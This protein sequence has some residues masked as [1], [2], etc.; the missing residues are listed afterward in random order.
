MADLL[1]TYY[2]CPHEKWAPDLPFDSHKCI[3]S[4]AL[5][6]YWGNSCSLFCIFHYF[7]Q[8]SLLLSILITPHPPTRP[9]CNLAR[10]LHLAAASLVIMDS[11][12]LCWPPLAITSTVGHVCYIAWGDMMNAWF[13]NAFLSRSENSVMPEYQS[14]NGGGVLIFPRTTACSVL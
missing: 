9:L 7:G 1:F 10:I 3:S 6:N 4:G 8:L 5:F 2:Q 12:S 13:A 14:K 11:K